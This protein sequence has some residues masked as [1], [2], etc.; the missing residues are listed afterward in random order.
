MMRRALSKTSV[1]NRKAQSKGGETTLLASRRRSFAMEYAP[2]R[3]NGARLREPL[4]GF[5][6]AIEVT[7]PDGRGIVYDAQGR[8][9]FF[10]V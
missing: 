2:D 5:G 10:E 9:L 3:A 8:F 6:Q 4:G 7:T 1:L